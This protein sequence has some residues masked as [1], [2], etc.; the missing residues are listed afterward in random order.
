MALLAYLLENSELAASLHSDTEPV[1]L[2]QLLAHQTD[3]DGCIALLN[4]LP[5]L[6]ADRFKMSNCMLDCTAPYDSL[7]GLSADSLGRLAELADYLIL[8]TKTIF[9]IKTVLENGTDYDKYAH[10][11]FKCMMYS[12]SKNFTGWSSNP[13]MDYTIKSPNAENTD[14]YDFHKHFTCFW[15]WIGDLRGLQ[16]AVETEGCEIDDYTCDYA[17]RGGYI[18]CLQYAR[19]HDAY[20]SIETTRYAAANGHLDCLVWLH[21][22]GCEWNEDTCDCATLY[23]HSDCFRYALNNGCPHDSRV[24][25]NLVTSGNL[26]DLI[27]ACEAGC[28]V[29]EGIC[30]L[31]TIYDHLNCLKWLR[32]KGYSW[33]SRATETAIR[34][35]RVDCLKYMIS[36]GCPYGPN[37]LENAASCGSY[38]CM[39][40]LHEIIGLP[41]NFH[42]CMSTLRSN[43]IKCLEYV[44]SR[45]GRLTKKS[46]LKLVK[47]A[48]I[49]RNYDG[50]EWLNRIGGCPVDLVQMKLILDHRT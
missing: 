39:V 46:K 48:I 22:H 34:N 15:A 32:S 27:Y 47:H 42:I 3:F 35:N 31:A 33:D 17:A 7:I 49:N 21:E 25:N 24:C 1:T 6:L 4:R 38:D 40:Y 13:K 44:F 50:L 14:Y 10:G 16:W 5:Q 20:W 19:M 11:F 9:K 8:P 30:I 43:C 18:E 41:L 45:L 12:P 36:E 28:K 26:K 29:W 2:E 37:I 23:K